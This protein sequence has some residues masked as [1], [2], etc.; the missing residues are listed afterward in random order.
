M[1][2]RALLAGY[3]THLA[4]IDPEL[5]GI[6]AVAARLQGTVLLARSKYF[7]LSLQAGS[8]LLLASLA[9]ELL[10]Q[11]MPALVAVGAALLLTEG[12]TWWRSA[13]QAARISATEFT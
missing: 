10:I 11:F 8:R 3:L 6:V 13:Q 7:E 4:A 9:T 1:H 2:R 5:A 12:L